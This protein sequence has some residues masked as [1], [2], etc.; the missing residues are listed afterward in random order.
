MPDINAPSDHRSFTQAIELL[1]AL[2]ADIHACHLGGTVFELRLSGTEDIVGVDWFN[3]VA[4][5]R[6]IVEFLKSNPTS[7]A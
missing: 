6:Q 7:S 4:L 1:R 5:D 3:L 2:H